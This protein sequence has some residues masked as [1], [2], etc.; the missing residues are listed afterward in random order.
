MAFLVLLVIGTPAYSQPRL[1]ITGAGREHRLSL[2]PRIQ[3]ALTRFDAKFKIWDE[4]FYS[5]ELVDWYPHTKKQ[6]PFAAIG[7]FNGDGIEDVAVH[8]ANGRDEAIYC[9]LSKGRGFRVIAAEKYPFRKRGLLQ[10]YLTAVPK[11]RVQLMEGTLQTKTDAFRLGYWEKAS[12]IY[13]YER[14][15]FKPI[16]DMD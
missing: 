14:G 9:V 11:G 12:S 1:I 5:V 13:L 2:P 6:A 7:D 15:R 16:Q 8:G 4:A 10:T 3:R